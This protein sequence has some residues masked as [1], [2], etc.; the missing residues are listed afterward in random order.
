MQKSLFLTLAVL[1]LGTTSITAEFIKVNSIASL[2]N[3]ISN[4][5]PGDRIII[6]NGLYTTTGNIIISKQGNEEQPITVEAE[7]IGGVEI[8]GTHGFTINSPSSYIIIKGFIFTHNTGR[9]R[10]E[11]GA[12]H[13]LITRNIFECVPAGTTGSKPYLSI[14]GDDNEIS[15]NTFQNKK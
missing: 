6:A 14:S 3:A 7:T 10:I 2:Q 4:A 11:T 15:Y 8:G 12:T 9:S 1:L 13:C 5:Y